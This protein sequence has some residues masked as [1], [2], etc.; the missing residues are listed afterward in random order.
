MLN[1]HLDVSSAAFNVG[2]EKPLAIQPRIS[3]FVRRYSQER[4]YRPARAG[5]PIGY[6]L[7]ASINPDQNDRA[8]KP[9]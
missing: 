5:S 1:E 8:D 2:Y 4:Y 6:A 3:P 7:I 9:D